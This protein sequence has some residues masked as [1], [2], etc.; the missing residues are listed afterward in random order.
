MA[1]VRAGPLRLRVTLSRQ[2]LPAVGVGTRA[3]ALLLTLLLTPPL[4]FADGVDMAAGDAAALPDRAALARERVRLE[5]AFDAEEAVCR[6]RFAVND[7]LDAVR[8]RRR[9]ALA[10]LRERELALAEAERRERA[11]QRR[12]AIET[13]Q[14]ALRQPAPAAASA[15][16]VRVRPQAS[17]VGARGRAPAARPEAN[18]HP[19]A[20]AASSARRA[21]AEDDARARAAQAAQR[22]AAAERRR[23]QARATQ[24][25]VEQR[26]RE[27]AAA[28]KAPDTLPPPSAPR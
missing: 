2:A 19:P 21:G 23:E 12:R 11:A 14:Q 13:R 15:P 18:A 20:A 27:R 9:E 8:Q 10:P 26:L 4:A 28:G 25:R 5:A 6:D 17:G 16:V 3:L 7:C 22:A 24:E 1:R